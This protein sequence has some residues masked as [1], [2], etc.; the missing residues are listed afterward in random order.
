MD[1]GLSCTICN[2]KGW[3][4]KRVKLSLSRSEPPPPPHSLWKVLRAKTGFTTL[5][6]LVQIEVKIPWY[7]IGLTTNK[8]IKVLKTLSNNTLFDSY[9]HIWMWYTGI[10]WFIIEQE[11]GGVLVHVPHGGP[12]REKFLVKF[13][14]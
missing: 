14:A 7:N 4:A 3:G 10:L 9:Y 5:L 1:T 6:K 12:G 2:V 11:K 13:S 8:L